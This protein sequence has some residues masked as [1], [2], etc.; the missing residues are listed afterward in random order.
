MKI[1]S[2]VFVCLF[3]AGCASAPKLE[4]PTGNKSARHPINVLQPPLSETMP[5]KPAPT[6]L[7]QENKV[8][9]QTSLFTGP[10]I[11]NGS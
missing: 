6:G 9:P 1:L 4:Y 11:R 8:V 3:T 7:D 5:I 2:V 10:S